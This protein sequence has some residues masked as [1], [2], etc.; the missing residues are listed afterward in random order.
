MPG[1]DKKTLSKNA[2]QSVKKRTDEF[3]EDDDLDIDAEVN[4][5]ISFDQPERSSNKSAISRRILEDY[6]EEKRLQRELK[7]DFDF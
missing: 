6:L 5:S 2:Q 4:D 7:D 3:I 1:K